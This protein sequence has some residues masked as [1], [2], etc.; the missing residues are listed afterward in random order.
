MGCS[1]AEVWGVHSTPSTK[2][3]LASGA[4]SVL[5]SWLMGSPSYNVS[6]E[7]PDSSRWR[8]L[9]GRDPFAEHS[10]NARLEALT[11]TVWLLAT[12]AAAAH[13]HSPTQPKQPQVNGVG[14]GSGGG[15]GAGGYSLVCH[16]SVLRGSLGTPNAVG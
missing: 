15:A 2:S 11:W 14:Y 9:T 13:V 5:I 1:I 12:S 16:G 4:A 7:G 8:T 3:G 6:V 10:L